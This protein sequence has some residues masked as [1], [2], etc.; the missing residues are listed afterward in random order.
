V[1]E[2]KTTVAT[3]SRAPTAVTVILAVDMERVIVIV[4]IGYTHTC[5]DT[6][7]III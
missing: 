2:G 7:P 6:R 5:N 1:S 3:C 4:T